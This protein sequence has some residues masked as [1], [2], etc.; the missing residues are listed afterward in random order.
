MKDLSADK[1]PSVIVILLFLLLLLLSR[2]LDAQCNNASGS[3]GT[4][5][6]APFD[7]CGDGTTTKFTADAVIYANGTDFCYGTI[8]TVSYDLLGQFGG[9]A[10]PVKIYMATTTATSW[11]S[12]VT[13]N[14]VLSG[15]TLVY[16]NNSQNWPALGWQTFTLNT[17]FTYTTGNLVIITESNQNAIPACGTGPVWAYNTKTNSHQYWWSTTS[18]GRGTSTGTRDQYRPALKGGGIF[19]PILLTSFTARPFEDQVELNWSTSAEVNNDHFTIERSVDGNVF[20][21]IARVKGAGNSTA[22]LKYNA[23]DEAPLPGISYYRLTQTDVS[24]DSQY[25]DIV[26]VDRSGI[27]GNTIDRVRPN[28]A[29]EE[30]SFDFYARCKGTLTIEVKD[31]TGRS[32]KALQKEVEAGL[33]TVETPLNDVAPGIYFLKASFDKTGYSSTHKVIKN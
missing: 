23:V 24:G 3:S 21:S 20:E 16:T 28:P 4:S 7:R 11:T 5:I 2:Q 29:N 15:A 8:N 31:C 18:A 22:T 14:S 25:S 30:V 1:H 19:L 10:F 12:N 27:T 26:F 33:S 9:S 32:L 17:P 13:Y 6:Y